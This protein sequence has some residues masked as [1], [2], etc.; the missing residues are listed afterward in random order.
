MAAV[1]KLAIAGCTIPEICAITGH[2]ERSAVSVLKHDLAMTGDMADAAIQ[3]LIDFDDAQ[4]EKA[5]QADEN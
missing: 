5:A 3:K 4:E 1:T 2:S